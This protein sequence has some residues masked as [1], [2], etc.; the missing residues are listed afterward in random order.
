MFN[1]PAPRHFVSYGA[2][3]QRTI[4]ELASYYDGILVPGTIA[5][6]QREGTAGFVLTQS[7]R[8]GNTTYVIDPRFP[9]FQQA[10]PIAKASHESLAK[11]LGDES[12]VR[13]EWPHPREFT[14]QR[15]D[16]IASAWVAFNLGYQQQQSA[17]FEKYAKRLGAPL[18]LSDASGP[19]RILAPY[20]CVEGRADPWYEKSLELYQATSAA[21]NAVGCDIDV[22]R[23]VSAHSATALADV[24]R[25]ND[26]DDVCIW[27]SGLDERTTAVDELAVYA[28]TVRRLVASGGRS[29]ALYGGFFAVLL[30]CVGLG[31]NSHGIGYG[32]NRKWREL[33][34]SGPPPA[35]YYLPT[36]HRY[37]RQDHAEALWRFD[38]ALVGGRRVE[39]PEAM[40]Y[41]DLMLHAVKARAAEIKNF[42][43]LSLD[44]AIERLHGEHREFTVRLEASSSGLLIERG[45]EFAGHVPMWIRVLRQVQQD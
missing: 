24:V 2:S 42:G 41:H 4:R 7:A 28:S 15:I 5:A 22:T 14:A 23:I 9:L 25:E 13:T 45:R 32:E 11:I 39:S 38:R 40:G 29:F 8:G 36:V 19:Q 20:F 34:Q 35:R 21:A 17:K 44:E 37:V 18:R 6:L 30:T 16:T 1:E 3:D 33:P 26:K 27:V 10:L 43:P 31:G 12:L